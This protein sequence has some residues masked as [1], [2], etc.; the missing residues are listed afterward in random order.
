MHTAVQ[1][2]KLLLD[3]SLSPKSVAV[4]VGPEGGLS[5]TEVEQAETSGFSALQ[6]GPR[7]F[8]SET[9]PVV[10]LSLLQMV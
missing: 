2:S 1:E 3:Q 8:R 6:L 4:L 7:V 5:S 10:A 9:A